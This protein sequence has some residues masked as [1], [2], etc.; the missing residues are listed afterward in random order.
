MTVAWR[1]CM[2]AAVLAIGAETWMPEAVYAELV[3]IK[4]KLLLSRGFW[5]KT[6]LAYSLSSVFIGQ[7][8]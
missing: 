2:Q 6:P 3:Q 8:S 1:V 7:C 5:V 4:G